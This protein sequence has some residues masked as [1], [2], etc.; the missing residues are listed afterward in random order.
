[1]LSRGDSMGIYLNPSN[2]DFA[3]I[4]NGVYIDK[5]GL[6]ALI[7]QKINTPAKLLCISRPRRFGKSYAAKMLCAYY[8]H[9]CD[10]HSLFEK[11]EISKD[12]SY[13]QHINKY[14]V[15]YL[16]V[17]GFLSDL[18]RRKDTVQNVANEI[19]ETIQRE[20]IADCPEVSDNLRVS[21]CLVRYV[22]LT[23]R[24]IV[25]IFFKSF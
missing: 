18:K 25:F 1:M 21:D 14:H 10:S 12:A 5:T 9:T 6:I 24:K 2:A 23:G 22:Q 11:Y 19:A 3:E 20:V 4:L 15:I 17:A 7:N 16:D 8:D 13:E